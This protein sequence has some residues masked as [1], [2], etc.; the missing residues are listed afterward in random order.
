MSAPEITRA[1]VFGV[2]FTVERVA[3][4]QDSD[5]AGNRGVILYPEDGRCPGIKIDSRLSQD[6]QKEALW[7]ELTHAADIE[8]GG[9]RQLAHNT[10]GRIS[11]AQYALAHDNPDIAAW[12]FGPTE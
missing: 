3:A 6:E 4:N 7:H 10:L 8:L 5:L 2:W 12:I 9:G 11:R 1:R